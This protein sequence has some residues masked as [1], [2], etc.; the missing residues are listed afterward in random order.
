[1]GVTVTPS[2]GLRR[3]KVW[4][5]VSGLG[6]VEAITDIADVGVDAVAVEGLG[7]AVVAGGQTVTCS[8]ERATACR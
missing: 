6:L 4:L 8:S 5:P 1:M 2:A 3:L 7:I